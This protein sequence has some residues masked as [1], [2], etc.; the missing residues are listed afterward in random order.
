MDVFLIT[1]FVIAIAIVA[2][3]QKEGDNG[4]AQTI[5]KV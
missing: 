2:T 5:T 3:S 1:S 4:H